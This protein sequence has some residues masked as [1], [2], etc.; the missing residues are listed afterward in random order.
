M[1]NNPNNIPAASSGQPD[2]PVYYVPVDPAVNE[3]RGIRKLGNA[4]GGALLVQTGLTVILELACLIVLVQM[5]KTT[6]EALSFL[7]DPRVIWLYH[8]VV[9]TIIMILPFVIATRFA[10]TKVALTANYGRPEKGTLWPLFLF[11]I[12]VIAMSNI[13]NNMFLSAIGYKP[14]GMEFFFGEYPKGVFGTA[15]VVLASAAVPALVEEFAFRGVTLGILRRVSDGFAILVSAL[16]FSLMHANITQMPFVFL[17][18]L[19]LGYMTVVS[20]SVWPAV[21]LHF[22]NNLMATVIDYAGVYFSPSM[23]SAVDNLYMMLA[24]LLGLI[25]FG[26]MCRDNTGKYFLKKSE[27]VNRFGKR[28]GAVMTSP[29]VIIYII[30]VVAEIAMIEAKRR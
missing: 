19:Y 21:L 28:L 3:R 30:Y 24:P 7:N 13:A 16:M 6:S 20:G 18:G 8:S 10:G 5:G 27:H 29:C 15:M 12:C 23:A 26:L 1:E 25:G 9:S 14:I 2:R 4:V 22:F 17:F 11:G